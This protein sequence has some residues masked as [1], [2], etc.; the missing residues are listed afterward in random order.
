[1]SS[2]PPPPPQPSEAVTAGD[3][4]SV[5]G[6]GGDSDS[7]GEKVPR[8]LWNYFYEKPQAGQYVPGGKAPAAAAAVNVESFTQTLKTLGR[9]RATLPDFALF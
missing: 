2:A 4:E 3:S 1:M 8:A 7:S 6:S 9:V 5:S